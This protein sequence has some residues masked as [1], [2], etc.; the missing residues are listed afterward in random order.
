MI[1]AALLRPIL[2]R[3]SLDLP[4]AARTTAT[5]AGAVDGAPPTDLADRAAD[6]VDRGDG[7][8]L[9]HRAARDGADPV[10]SRP[11]SGG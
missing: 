11:P 7:T 3:S 2:L 4:D 8:D 10:P 1:A 5:A 6:L 9:A